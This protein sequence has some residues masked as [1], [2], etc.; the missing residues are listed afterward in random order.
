MPI[1]S[2]SDAQE[3]F[4]YLLATKSIDSAAALAVGLISAQF[5]DTKVNARELMSLDALQQ[6][7]V[8]PGPWLEG[9]AE[10]FATAVQ[11]LNHPS[12]KKQPL[13]KFLTATHIPPTGQPYPQSVPSIKAGT[14]A[15]LFL[16][17][18]AQQTK[19]LAEAF[20]ATAG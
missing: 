7:V 11:W 18:P 6:R 14:Y 16:T 17:Q 9:I 19:A 2:R 15:D 8:T 4:N 5:L 13:G 3:Q 1:L 10:V 20:R 12:R